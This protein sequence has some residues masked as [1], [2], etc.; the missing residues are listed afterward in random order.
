MK[1][2]LQFSVH[3]FSERKK[4]KPFYCDNNGQ[5]HMICILIKCEY[6]LILNIIT[7]SNCKQE[8]IEHSVKHNGEF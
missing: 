4:K 7:I 8:E 5:C 3:K 1:F 2:H 6:D